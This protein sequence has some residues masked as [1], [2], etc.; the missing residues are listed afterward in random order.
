L[1]YRCTGEA[2]YYYPTLRL[3]MQASSRKAMSVMYYS[4]A[5]T[6]CGC[7]ISCKHEQ[8]TV[9]EAAACISRAGGYVVG[10]E[11][12]AMRS[13]TVEEESEFQS[14]VPSHSTDSSA[15][16]TTPA[17]PAEA[18]VSDSVYAVMTRIRV[19]DGW[20]WTTWMRFETYAEA[21]EHA[22]EANKVVR[23]GS[24]EWAVLRQQT[25]AASPIVIDAPRESPPPQSEG[26]TLLEFVLRFLSAYGFAQ[27]ADPISDVKHGLIVS[28]SANTRFTD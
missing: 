4:A 12:G 9:L 11:N 21:A 6:E 24:S 25:E 22:R 28:V 8:R 18:A 10:V 1:K 13:L 5:W 7:L 3:C 16:E 20:T 2:D 27:Q 15:I 17:S 23:F 14:A 26:E 19:G